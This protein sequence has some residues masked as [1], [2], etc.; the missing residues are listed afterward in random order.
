MLSTTSPTR[1]SSRADHPFNPGHRHRANFA[2][3]AMFDAFGVH[4]GKAIHQAKFIDH[5][6][7]AWM[8]LAPGS[9][10]QR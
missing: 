5:V 8:R 7:G 9:R 2:R 10:F 3:Q 6:S 1:R 4:H